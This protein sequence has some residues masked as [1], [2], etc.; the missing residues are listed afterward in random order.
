VTVRRLAIGLASLACLSMMMTRAQSPAQAPRIWDDA[1]LADWAT[2]IA[3]LTLRPPHYSAAEYYSV[4][5]DN[6]RTVSGFSR[7]PEV[8]CHTRAEARRTRL[9]EGG[10]VDDV[11]KAKAAAP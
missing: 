1:A 6:L 9:R 11:T 10:T 4:P 3:A 8:S 2:P 5:G 7:R